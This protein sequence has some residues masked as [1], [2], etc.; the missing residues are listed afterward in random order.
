MKIGIITFHF[1][2]NQGAVLQCY[3]LQCFLKKQGYDV[4]V[5]N[6]CPSYHTNRYSAKRNP[7]IM[8]VSS[9]KK[10]R[11]AK[12]QKKLYHMVRSF[13]KGIYISIAG[14]YKLREKKFAEFTKTHLNLSGE[15]KT[16]KALQK[17]PPEC[18]AYISG[19]DQLWNPDLVNSGFDSAYFLNF[20]GSN[21]KKI[22]YA[23]SLRENYT[24][25]EKDEIMTYCR[26]INV[27]SSRERSETLYE[28]LGENYTVCVDPTLLL[29]KEEYADAENEI[30]EAEPYIFVYGFE[31]SHNILEAVDEI[32]K[33][34]GLR[35]INGSP[36][37]V[38]L[39]NAIKLCNYG[40][41]EFLSYIKNADFVITNSFHGTA[42]SLIYNKQ[43][44]TVAHTT[45]GR[46]MTELLE[47]V[48]LSE[49]I[50]KEK[51]DEWKKEIDY[52]EVEQK[53]NALKQQSAEYLNKSLK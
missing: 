9:L 34:T 39:N 10:N 31:S 1:A 42:F 25:E 43:F 48:G 51:N 41:G 12:I 46:R 4:E 37:R 11:N 52:A 19:S 22:T 7:F 24:Q 50:W 40:P 33:K 49:R 21:I 30:K 38:M 28:L 26:N 27:I 16:L 44:V 47:K 8:A 3:A 35:I 20:G 36:D 18:D 45:R 2:H 53:R 23:V 29:E 15:Y 32:S 17:M 6:Y 14:T 13:A 5:I